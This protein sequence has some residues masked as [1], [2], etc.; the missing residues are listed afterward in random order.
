MKHL[1]ELVL[2]IVSV[3]MIITA[4][5]NDS[6]SSTTHSKPET[7]Q[8]PT[9]SSSSI[10]SSASSSREEITVKKRIYANADVR[11]LQILP[12]MQTIEQH[13]L[14]EG[15]YDPN[16]ISTF[17]FNGGTVFKGSEAL[18]SEILEN[19]KNPGLGVRSL[20]EQGI[21]GK[22]V[23]VAIIDANLLLN[24]P[25]YS[26]KITEYHYLD[27]GDP[28][29]GSFHGPGVT[30]LLVGENIGTA[31]D[32]SVYYVAVPPGRANGILDSQ[33][34]ADAL[35]WIV[36]Q[37]RKLPNDQKIRVVSISAVP[38]E[39]GRENRQAYRDAV[40]LAESEGMLVIDADSF[41][42]SAYYE[43]GDN[44]DDVRSYKAG[45]PIMGPQ[46]LSAEKIAA[47]ASVRTTAEHYAQDSPSY[48]YHGNGGVSWAVPYTAGVLA[49][50]WQVNPALG[51]DEIVEL[52][53]ETAYVNNDGVN[54]INPPSFIEAVKQIEK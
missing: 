16:D 30:S 28:E 40:A 39:A 21:T 33:Y 1:V 14:E 29:Q 2:V 15:E 26:G 11:N 24:H 35:I 49:M 42:W 27:V 22:G 52:L 10:P 32:A 51:N 19:G 34:C 25:E 41:V 18:A 38:D 43:Y 50:G 54:I 20:H 6:V 7:E 36:E 4:C 47:P 9:P 5:S 13:I 53:F 44:P 45:Y 3:L 46:P 23:N 17:R 12:E 48:V 31:P 8:V 37:N